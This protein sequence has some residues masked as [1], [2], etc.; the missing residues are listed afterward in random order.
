MKLKNLF[1]YFMISM[2]LISVSGCKKDTVTKGLTDSE[3]VEGL[4]DALIVGTTNS[5]LNANAKDG[6]FG[7]SLIKIPFPPEA[8]FVMD[9]VAVVP[10]GQIVIDEFVLK[11]NR[12]A[13]NAAIKAKPI[14]INAITGMTIT[15]AVN[16]LKGSDNA[17]TTY[18]QN[19]TSGQL[20]TAFRPDI[21]KSLE[22][23]GAQQAW[24]AVT[25]I[26]NLNPFAK[27]VNTDLADYTTQRSLDGLF[28]LV[29]GEETKIRKDPAARVDEV[30]KKVFDQA[31]W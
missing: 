2:F 22:D 13:E 7:N 8:K 24:K 27:P 6:Y 4:K 16:I 3:I 29:A 10:G 26:Y 23:V 31:N 20:K 21:Q 5:V 28:T 18:L 9:A 30:L 14:F 17:A 15:D 25:D 12:A 1:C 19:N 11:V